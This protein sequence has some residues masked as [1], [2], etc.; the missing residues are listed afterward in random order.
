LVV[1]VSDNGVGLKPERLQKLLRQITSPE[2]MTD[3]VGLQNI[4]RRLNLYY[5]SAAVL[6]LKNA[7]E[8]GMI[9]ITRIPA[10]KGA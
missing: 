1:E 5:G 3:S 9:A 7:P 8:H 6:E 2:D 10:Q 4:Y